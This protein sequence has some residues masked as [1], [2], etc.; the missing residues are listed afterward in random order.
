MKWRVGERFFLVAW[1]SE[2]EKLSGRPSLQVWQSY[3][4]G[5][6]LATPFLERSVGWTGSIPF[7][8]PWLVLTLWVRP[9]PKATLVSLMFLGLVVWHTISQWLAPSS[10]A[11][12]TH[13]DSLIALMLTFV[14]LTVQETKKVTRAFSIVVMTL[15]LFTAIIGLAKLFLQDR[16]VLL[17]PI[18]KWCPGEYLHGTVLC[19]DYN[20][21]A[22]TWLCALAVLLADRIE[23]KKHAHLVL[24]VPLIAAGLAVGSRRFLLLLPILLLASTLLVW[25]FEGLRQAATEGARSA[26][27]F[28]FALLLLS[29]VSAPEEYEEFRLGNQ[30]FTILFDLSDD[31]RVGSAE[32][33]WSVR[34]VYPDIVFQSI[35]EGGFAPRLE[36]WYF[37]VETLQG[38]SLWGSGFQYHE[39]FSERFVQGC[40]LDY[41]HLPLMSEGLIGGVPLFLLGLAIYMLLSLRA[42]RA[43]WSGEA[44]GLGMMFVLASGVA[45]ISGDTMLSISLWV[46]VSLTIAA[47]TRNGRSSVPGFLS[48]TGKTGLS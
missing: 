34:T 27:L 19:G 44:V 20:L 12:L 18:L 22:L 5:V 41:P 17:G 16:G 10:F 21:L 43:M 40:F 28:L 23:G 47:V 39:L 35:G 36:R 7:L 48:D 26:V 31:V 6:A 46:T 45:M 11:R 15:G 1:L 8:I 33:D 25:R 4:T 9:K 38:G 24:A 30:Q 3:A 14:A 29:V 2:L 42:A 32:V 13:H 37:G